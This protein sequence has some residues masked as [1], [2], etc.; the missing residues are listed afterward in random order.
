MDKTKK[1]LIIL[2]PVT[3]CALMAIFLTSCGI[4]EQKTQLQKVRLNEDITYQEDSEIM[5]QLLDLSKL[6]IYVG[7][8]LYNYDLRESVIRSRKKM[9][10]TN[11][12]KILEENIVPDGYEEF[13]DTLRL[14][15]EL[16]KILRKDKIKRGYLD[17]DVDEA[18]AKDER[19]IELVILKNRNGKT[20]VKIGYTFIPKFNSFDETGVIVN[21]D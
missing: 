12:N 13:A 9:T 15:H 14:M 21:G 11:V 5:I 20:G 3:F 6:V 18:K 19:Q 17:F 2:F 8:A 10:Y 4:L 7:R 1:F 16:S